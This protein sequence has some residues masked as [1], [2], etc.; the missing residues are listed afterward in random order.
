M[1]CPGCAGPAYGCERYR[2]ATGIDR[3]SRPAEI[4]DSVAVSVATQAR[5]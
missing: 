4:F 5:P 2:R 1:L 3:G